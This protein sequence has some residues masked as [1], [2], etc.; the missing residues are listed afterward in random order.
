MKNEAA[1][2]KRAAEQPCYR[3]IYKQPRS[4]WQFVDYRGRL[5][6][7]YRVW[8]VPNIGEGPPR[9]NMMM[10]YLA[11]YD[12]EIR[13][14]T[15]QQAAAKRIATGFDDSLLGGMGCI[16]DYATMSDNMTYVLMKSKSLSP[17]PGPKHA[18]HVIR[19]DPDELNIVHIKACTDVVP[20]SS[21]VFVN[22]RGH[23][24]IEWRTPLGHIFYE[25][26]QSPTFS[27]YVVREQVETTPLRLA[28]V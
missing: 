20:S 10:V 11:A 8:D 2:R 24:C 1:P 23:L 5:W 14:L 4:T 19:F 28:L 22:N 6:Q 26:Q 16:V 9:V 13:H 7:W 3:A 12:V 15:F 18:F 21:P 27:D 17:G 25:P